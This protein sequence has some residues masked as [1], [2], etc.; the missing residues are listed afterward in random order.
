MRKLYFLKA[1]YKEKRYDFLEVAWIFTLFILILSV[2]VQAENWKP[3]SL[4]KS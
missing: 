3:F 2:R 4:F 1:I